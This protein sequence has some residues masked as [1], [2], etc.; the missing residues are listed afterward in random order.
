MVEVISLFI[1]FNIDPIDVTGKV[2]NDI[3][4]F[5]IILIILISIQVQVR[6]K[7]GAGPKWEF[8]IKIQRGARN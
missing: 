6:K 1:G 2:L 4:F 5:M 7:G 8:P 3:Y